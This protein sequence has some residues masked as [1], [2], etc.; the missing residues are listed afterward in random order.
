MRVFSLNTLKCFLNEVVLSLGKNIKRTALHK[1]L[2]GYAEYE[3]QVF[4]ALT[5]NIHACYDHSLVIPVYDESFDAINNLLSSS[6]NNVHVLFI[7]VVNCPAQSDSEATKRTLQL[8]DQLLASTEIAYKI[9]NI[10]YSKK[11]GGHGLILIDKCSEFK[12][13]PKKQGVGLAR[14]TGA[15]IACSLIAK[16]VV[17]SRWIH[18]TDADVTLPNDYFCCTENITQNHIALV[19][20]FEHIPESGYEIAS[21]LYDLSLRYYVE[22]LHWAGSHYAYHSIGSLI[23]VDF[24]AYAKVRGFPKRAG[25]EDFYLLNKLAKVGELLSL[26]EPVIKVAARPSHRVPFGTGPALNKIVEGADEP[27]VFYHPKTFNCLKQFITSLEHADYTLDDREIKCSAD[28]FPDLDSHT[29]AALDFLGFCSAWSHA[30]A[31]SSSRSQNPKTQFIKQITTWFDAFM[32]LKFIHFLRNNVYS[33]I[34]LSELNTQAD[35]LSPE[36]KIK[37]KQL[38]ASI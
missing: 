10:V 26:E 4:D 1:Y 30:K 25:G 34:A 36:L 32:T 27:F 14:K 20:P 12:Q 29:L 23:A 13:I 18:S 9:D 5:S 37:L 8:W 24:E 2:E 38:I 28:I 19:Y 16:G 11:Q 35:Y 17:S 6:F 33:S 21:E 22:S 7:L 15:D 3:D 31:H